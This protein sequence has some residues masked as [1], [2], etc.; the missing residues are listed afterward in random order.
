MGG[1]QDCIFCRIIAKQVPSYSIFEDEVCLAL[2]DINPASRGHVLLLP[3]K[4]AVLL[5]QLPDEIVAHMGQVAKWISASIAREVGADGVTI[6]CAAGAA[7]GQNSPHAMIHLIPRK[8]NDGLDL[9]LKGQD[10]PA[11][12]IEKLAGAM[13]N[14]I[15]KEFG[16]MPKRA[17]MGEKNPKKENSEPKEN[18]PEIPDKSKRISDKPDLDSI[19][20]MLLGEGEDD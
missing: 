15:I 18:K 8:Q 9:G 14:A 16:T 17:D 10:A 6:F 7:A 13:S 2:L 19:T 3:K 20:S 4:H 1:E 5:A 11:E 12:Q